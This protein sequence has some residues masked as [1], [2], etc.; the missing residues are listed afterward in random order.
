MEA[1]ISLQHL[2]QH[3]GQF[4]DAASHEPTQKL[5]FGH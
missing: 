2:G 1:Q 4:D 5:L 3:P